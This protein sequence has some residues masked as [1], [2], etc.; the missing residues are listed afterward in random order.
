MSHRDHANR[1][2]ET[3][4][5]AANSDQSKKSFVDMA[6]PYAVRTV[7]NHSARNGDR[8]TGSELNFDSPYASDDFLSQ[9]HHSKSDGELRYILKRLAPILQDLIHELDPSFESE[10]SYGDKE[11]GTGRGGRFGGGARTVDEQDATGDA[12]GAAGPRADAESR[13]FDGLGEWT[14]YDQGGIS[15]RVIRDENGNT[16]SSAGSGSFEDL[17]AL[18]FSPQTGQPWYQYND[19]YEAPAPSN[20]TS[21]NNPSTDLDLSQIRGVNLNPDDAQFFNQT[22]TNGK[23]SLDV[24]HIKGVNL[25]GGEWG[26]DEHWP[27]TQEIRD[28]AAKGFNTIRLAMSWEKLQPQLGGPL[29]QNEL[30]H[31]DEI[32]RTAAE[33]GIKVMPEMHNYDRYELGHAPGDNGA[34]QTNNGT[35]VGQ[36]GL[37][38]SALSDLWTKVVKH[39]NSD[40]T[41]SSAIAGWDLMNEPY[42]TN[43]T[44]AQ[45]ALEVDQAI[46]ATGDQHTVIVEGDNWA[47]DFNGL[48]QLNKIDPNIAFSAHSYWYQ[49]GSGDANVGVNAI[50]DF[51]NWLAANDAV[52]FIGE[53]GV[54]VDDPSWDPAVVNFIKE[55]AAH[56]LGNM[57]WAGGPSWGGNPLSVEPEGGVY[58]HVLETIVQANEEFL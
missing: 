26:G 51:E 8:D 3:D 49:N 13:A 6:N 21:A 22:F 57:V 17:N 56:G 36:D 50:K 5:P 45:T 14:P 42:N 20:Q 25:S 41:L 16:N 7:F 44:W 33:V 40:V 18:I 52:G 54:P 55:T 27:T 31:L 53:F 35:I 47:T 2:C 24:A 15:H 38:V 28:Y 58:P 4:A 19:P 12:T 10:D 46:R 11:A 32:L 9:H 39:V 23:T 34:A 48:E 37:P 43:G 1:F 29:D 30:R